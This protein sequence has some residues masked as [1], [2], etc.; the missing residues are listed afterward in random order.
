[1]QGASVL[2][3]P[4][5]SA[6][7]GRQAEFARSRGAAIRFDPECSPFAALDGRTADAFGDLSVLADGQDVWM[8][9]P[10]PV[11]IAAKF[12]IMSQSDCLQMRADSVTESASRP[13]FTELTDADAPDMR[14]LA[15]LTEPGP[16]LS[17]THR[18]GTF[19][20]IRENGRLV[21]MAGERLKPDGFTEMSGV[22]TH[23]D[24]RGRGYAGFL[25][26]EAARR[27]LG[28]GEIPFLH[29][30]AANTGAVALY[31]ACGFRTERRMILTVLRPV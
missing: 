14:E 4:V 31:E 10:E 19:I 13:D 27:C 5:R 28:R 6:L 22:C 25:I 23:P 29:C 24:S 2:S 1:M 21:A 18:L 3:D 7:S 11:R 8:L 30:Y 26:K 20:G 17:R 16:F 12:S 9:T 15:A